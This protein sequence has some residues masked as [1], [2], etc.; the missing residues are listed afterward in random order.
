MKWTKVLNNINLQSYI[1][2]FS[3]GQQFNLIV[4]LLILFHFNSL[5]L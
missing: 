4:N 2:K 1:I 3:N 5:E